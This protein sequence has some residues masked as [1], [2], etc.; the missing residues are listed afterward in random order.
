MNTKSELRCQL[1]AK[2]KAQQWQSQSFDICNHLAAADLVRPAQIILGF[3]CYR[4]E[5]DLEL[6]WR[7]LPAKTWGLPRCVGNRLDW[8]QI[9]PINLSASTQLGAF[10]ILEPLPH[11]P[12]ID[13][14]AVDLILVPAIALD[15]QGYR[16]GYG[17]GF[18]DR[19]LAKQAGIRVGI[20]FAEF[21]LENLPHQPW[22]IPMDYICTENGIFS[23]DTCKGSDKNVRI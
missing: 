9:S 16:L 14:E 7:K 5:P 6:L 12:H 17:G 10:N 4:Q 22:D 18:Y 2:R 19:F 23:V 8:H 3:S 15:R 21:F 11:L 1:L 20:I 13:L